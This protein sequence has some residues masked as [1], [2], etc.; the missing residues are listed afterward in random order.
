MEQHRQR[1]TQMLRAKNWESRKGTI[2]FATTC[3]AAHR[4]DRIGLTKWRTPMGLFVRQPRMMRHLTSFIGEKETTELI[5]N[6]GWIRGGEEILVHKSD[7]C[8]CVSQ[9]ITARIQQTYPNILHLFS[10]QTP[11]L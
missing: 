1:Y 4:E 3:Q 6:I 5:T 11:I 8:P 10:F 7:D 9:A 2:V